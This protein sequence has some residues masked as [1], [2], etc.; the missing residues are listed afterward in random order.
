MWSLEDYIID[1]PLNKENLHTL[2]STFEK[3]SFVPFVGAGPSTTLG[4]PNWKKLIDDLS[5]TFG[6]KIKP[7]KRDGKVDYPKAFS[8]LYKKLDNKKQFYNKIFENLWPTKTT[9]TGFYLRLV[10]LF[11]AYITTNYDSPIEI[12]Y[13]N[14]HNTEL[15][16][17]FFSCYEMSNFKDCIVYLHGHEDINFCI[18]KTEDYDYFYPTV[19]KKNGIPVLE[20]FLSEIFSKKSVIFAGFSFDDLYIEQFIRLLNAVEPF[21]NC[22]YWLLSESARVFSEIKQRVHQFN[23]IGRSDKGTLE[24]TKFFNGTTN[25]KPI[26]YKADF[27]IFIEKLFQRLIESLPTTIEPRETTGVP[28]R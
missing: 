14:Q 3:D 22:H 10:D 20:D 18:I 4:A 24:M 1:N 15:K 19:S 5:K 6:I 7:R 27:D 28:V 16:K 9:V 26:V 13:Q 2:I 8:N 12:A 23:Q 21:K 17:Y 25:I 11:Y